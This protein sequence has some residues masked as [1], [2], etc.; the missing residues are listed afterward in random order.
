MTGTA[1][2]Q[3]IHDLSAIQKRCRTISARQFQTY[4]LEGELAIFETEHLCRWV[5]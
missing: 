3:P 2:A 1:G 4:S 5:P